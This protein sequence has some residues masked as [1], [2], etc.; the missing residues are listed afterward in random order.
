M[1][2]RRRVMTPLFKLIVIFIFVAGVFFTWSVV[3]EV[4]KTLD[5]KS[6]LKKAEQ[7]LQIIKDENTKLISQ[8]DKLTDPNYVQN[9]ARGNY[10]LTKDGEE[11][12]YL[13]S[14]GE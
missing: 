6:Q 4:F 1:K 13:P 8:R 10:M 9:Y 12:F 7:Q 3:S 5:L 14:D 11:I 2:K